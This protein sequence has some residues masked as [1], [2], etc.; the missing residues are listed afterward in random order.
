MNQGVFPEF[1]R[2]N[3]LRTYNTMKKIT[4]PKKTVRTIANP[5]MLQKMPYIQKKPLKK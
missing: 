1:P 4:S 3:E 5:P 2:L